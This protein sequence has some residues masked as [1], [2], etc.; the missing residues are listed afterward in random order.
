MLRSMVRLETHL[1][2]G[3]RM[4]VIAKAVSSLGKAEQISTIGLCGV[5]ELKEVVAEFV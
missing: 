5:Y 2:K 3:F 4:C 1:E